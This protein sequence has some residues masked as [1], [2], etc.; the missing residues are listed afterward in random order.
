MATRKPKGTEPDIQL[1]TT[2]KCPS[3]SGRS[4]ITSSI[5]FDGE[6]AVQIKL[7]NNS[8]GGQFSN[9]S[10]PL[11]DI[12]KLLEDVPDGV[13]FTSG[14]FKTLFENQSS[15]N[16]AGFLLAVVLKEKLVVPQEGKRRKFV[17]NSPTAFLAKVEKLKA[18]KKSTPRRKAK[19]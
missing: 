16:N 19:S 6:G 4:Q 9:A 5:G 2:S 18:A 7:V 14:I 1:L 3:I 12:L 8:G 11:A 13:S 15:N 17:Y 10:I